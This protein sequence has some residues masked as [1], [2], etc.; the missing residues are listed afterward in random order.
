MKGGALM[1]CSKM[2]WSWKY[3]HRC[4]CKLDYRAW[5]E[6]M[7]HNDIFL[8]LKATRNVI[9]LHTRRFM[10][11]EL[12]WSARA[13]SYLESHLCRKCVRVCARERRMQSRLCHEAFSYCQSVRVFISHTVTSFTPVPEQS[14]EQSS[15]DP[16]AHRTASLLPGTR[17]A[18]LGRG[19]G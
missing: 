7:R 16:R 9:L 10:H 8:T 11:Q 12:L 4:N 5:R 6:R 2:M 18:A 14:L 1:M 15:A 3:K 17:T 19:L 13:G